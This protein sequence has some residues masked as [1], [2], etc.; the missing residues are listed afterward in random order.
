MTKMG[1]N[2]GLKVGNFLNYT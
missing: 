1:P 2:F